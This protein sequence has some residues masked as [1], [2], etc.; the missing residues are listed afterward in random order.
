[1]DQLS[2]ETGKSPHEIL[3]K[4]AWDNF[5]GI[6]VTSTSKPERAEALTRALAEGE[7]KLERGV[8]ERL[9]AAAKKDGYE[10]KQFYLHPH[11]NK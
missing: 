10:G 11:L 1:M 3:L 8:Y 7:R 6:L 4:W 5:D 9:E 2:R